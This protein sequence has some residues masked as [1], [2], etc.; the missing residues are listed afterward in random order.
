MPDWEAMGMVGGNLGFFEM[1]GNTP[2]DPF[3]GSYAD[4]AENLAKLQFAT[5][6]HDNYGL[7]YIEGGTRSP[8]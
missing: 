8:C 6:L 5:F 1:E 7:D 4:Q 3:K 2:S